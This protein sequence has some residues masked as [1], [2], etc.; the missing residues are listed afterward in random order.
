MF[1]A[2]TDRRTTSECAA[3]HGTVAR[4]DDPWWD[5]RIPPLHFNCR[6]SIRSLD[7]EQA[8]EQPKFAQPK[9]ET[10]GSDGFGW[11]PDKSEW[12]PDLEKY[13]AQIRKELKM[14]LAHGP[15]PSKLPRRE[16]PVAI[17]GPQ[18]G[19]DASRGGQ[20]A[21]GAVRS[22]ALDPEARVRVGQPPWHMDEELRP[23]G[24]TTAELGA[25]K[26]EA[27]ETATDEYLEAQGN[28]PVRLPEGSRKQGE[29]FPDRDINGIKVEYASV[30]PQE[31]TLRVQKALSRAVEKKADKRQ[32]RYLIVDLRMTSLTYEQATKALSMDNTSRASKEFVTLRLIGKT[33]DVTIYPS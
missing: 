14:R 4:A 28:S 12:E 9:P 11:K 23:R 25:K 16:P 24:K 29:K 21:P 19:P 20:W 2:V 17:T 32:A 7:E 13:E 1:S 10:R 3:L 8:K 5:G 27:H 33:F 26:P 18:T 30:F 6:S 22:D 15:D 31:E